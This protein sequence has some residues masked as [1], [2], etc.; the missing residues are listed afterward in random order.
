AFPNIYNSLCSKMN[1]YYDE[2][3]QYNTAS[4]S[5]VPWLASLFVAGLHL[6]FKFVSVQAT[7]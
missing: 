5:H 3:R 2:R 1:F 4:S 6:T 7:V